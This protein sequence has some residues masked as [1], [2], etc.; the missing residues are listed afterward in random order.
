MR[1]GGAASGP[2]P[3]PLL[4]YAHR[5]RPSHLGGW[6]GGD[7]KGGAGW[8]IISSFVVPP[9]ETF[10]SALGAVPPPRRPRPCTV[11]YPAPAARRLKESGR[12]RGAEAGWGRA[13]RRG[14]HP[15][16]FPSDR[17]PAPQRCRW[18]DPDARAARTRSI[19]PFPSLLRV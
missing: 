5:E 3:L 8:F 7:E 9:V 13:R 15:S 18:R 12:R 11:G 16:P 17:R 19:R 2:S 1:G 10:P 4:P 6:G 14:L